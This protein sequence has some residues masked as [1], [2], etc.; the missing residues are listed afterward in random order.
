MLH[1]EAVTEG[2]GYAAF[3]SSKQLLNDVIFIWF[4]DKKSVH[5]IHYGKF[6]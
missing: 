6:T 1:T 3:G 2:I 4:T 5:I